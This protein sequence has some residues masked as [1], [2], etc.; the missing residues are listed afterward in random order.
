MYSVSARS[1][2]TAIQHGTKRKLLPWYQT[3]ISMATAG[4]QSP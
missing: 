3:G 4:N 2:E 1:M